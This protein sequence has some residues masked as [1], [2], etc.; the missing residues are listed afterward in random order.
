[1]NEEIVPRCIK[2]LKFTCY[3]DDDD[4]QY[5]TFYKTL[6]YATSVEILYIDGLEDN[7][8]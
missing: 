6:K 7:L 5:C 8:K 1:M 4:S 3:L 2:H